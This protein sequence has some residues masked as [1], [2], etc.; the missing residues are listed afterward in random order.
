LELS[1]GTHSVEDVVETI[2]AAR[3]PDKGKDSWEFSEV[4]VSAFWKF[5]L[6]DAWTLRVQSDYYEEFWAE[7][8]AALKNERG[9]V[10]IEVTCKYHVG[11]ESQE[12]IKQYMPRWV[13]LKTGL[14]HVKQEEEGDEHPQFVHMHM[15]SFDIAPLR[16]EVG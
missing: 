15:V 4:Q 13:E 8:L 5:A 11:R 9:P 16:A 12:T 14:I 6:T 3:N 10:Q 2:A 7:L 1:Q